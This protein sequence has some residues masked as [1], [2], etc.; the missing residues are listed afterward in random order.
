MRYW[1]KNIGDTTPTI[2]T[3]GTEERPDEIGFEHEDL[4]S[5]YC[6]HCTIVWVDN[7]PSLTI[8]SD[9]EKIETEKVLV[10]KRNEVRKAINAKTD[11]MIAYGFVYKDQKVRLTL[12]DQWNYDNM[13][14]KVEK[15]LNA[16][17][18]AKSIFP[19]RF[20]VWREGVKPIYQIFES[21]AE[22]HDFADKA[23]EY[24]ETVLQ[25]GWS[26]KDPLATADENM[27]DNFKD[28]RESI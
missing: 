3:Y 6:I 7:I 1:A 19:V 12:F 27:L 23:F 14:R 8:P 21:L 5:L 13:L 15:H 2:F 16:G 26:L 9:I 10:K 24:V 22:L 4:P 18:L 11:T 25:S 28:T 17:V 20:K